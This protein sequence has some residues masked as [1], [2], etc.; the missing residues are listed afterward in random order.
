LGDRIV[1]TSIRRR[2]RVIALL[3]GVVLAGVVLMAFPRHWLLPLPLPCPRHGRVID[4]ETAQPVVGARLEVRWRI[5]DYPMIDGAGSYELEAKAITDNEGAFTL[6]VPRH[7]RGLWNTETLP[8]MVWADGYHT[9]TL[10]DWPQNVRYEDGK[11]IILMKPDE[12]DAD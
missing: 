12:E 6:P 2:R 10:A 11:V 7:R 5:Y 8:P 9:F 4:V 3:L 1:G